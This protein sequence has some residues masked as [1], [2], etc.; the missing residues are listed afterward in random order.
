MMQTLTKHD[1]IDRREVRYRRRMNLRVTTQEQAVEFIHD[2]GFAFL[3]P[4]QGVEMSYR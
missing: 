2:V 3:F 1:V 4:I